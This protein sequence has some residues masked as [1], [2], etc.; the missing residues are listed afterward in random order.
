MAP[1]VHVAVVVVWFLLSKGDAGAF[2]SSAAL[3][4][5]ATAPLAH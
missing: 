4:F 5:A 3:A 2:G 1:Q